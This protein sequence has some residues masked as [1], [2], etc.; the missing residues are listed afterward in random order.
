MAT[1]QVLAIDLAHSV[2]FRKGLGNSL[3]ASPHSAVTASDIKQ[4]ASEAFAKSNLAVVGTGISTEALSSAVSKAFGSGSGSSTL[5]ATA[6]KYYGGEQRVPLDLHA[7]PSAQPTLVIAYGSTSAPSPDM[8]AL[9]HLLGGES[10]LKWVPGTSPLSLAAAKFP[11]STAKSFL[12]PYSDASLFG[13]VISAPTDE[14]VKAL[15]MEV[16]NVIKGVSGGVKEEGLKKAVAKAKFVA[17]SALESKDGLAAIA[18]P[19][20][21]SSS[22]ELFGPSGRPC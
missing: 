6:T 18:G 1:P 14:A 13:I 22:R 21:G 4:Y 5:S 15:A 16:T 12:L 11:G 19:Q 17:A 7:N 10:S 20:V 9:P 3:F 2:A 8:L